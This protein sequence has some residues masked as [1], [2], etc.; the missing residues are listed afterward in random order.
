M[1][2]VLIEKAESLERCISQVHSYYVGHE[3]EFLTDFMRQDAIVLNLQRACQIAI[4]MAMRT[5][6]LRRLDLPESSAD[7]FHVLERAGLLESVLAARLVGMVGFRN[8]SVHEYRK[9]DMNVVR[10]I[11]EHHLADLLALSEAILR[12]DAARPPA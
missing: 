5:A 1:D 10:S 7:I 2:H 11:I 8:V 12:A 6:R 9:L 4:D 3:A